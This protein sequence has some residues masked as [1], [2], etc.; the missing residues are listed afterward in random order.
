MLQLFSHT[1]TFGIKRAAVGVMFPDI[2]FCE[3]IN[4]QLHID[5]FHFFQNTVLMKRCGFFFFQFSHKSVKYFTLKQI[6]C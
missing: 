3:V 6:F 5:I 2:L 4:L 1:H